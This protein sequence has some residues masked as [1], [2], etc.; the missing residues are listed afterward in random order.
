MRRRGL[1]FKLTVLYTTIFSVLLSGFFVFAYYL[2]A[3]Q[4][5]ATAT[6]E[7][8]ERATG[9]KGYLRFQN[10][11]PTLVFDADDPDVAYFS[12]TATRYY[13]IYDYRSG[14]LVHQSKELALMGMQFN[15]KEILQ[16]SEGPALMDI[17]TDQGPL[18]FYNDRIVNVLNYDTVH[19]GITRL[20]MTSV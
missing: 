13:Q 4:L 14:D 18:R 9:L 12:R 15:P 10:G 5:E 20:A 17:Q 3:N 6:D 16:F 11:A 1:R 7:L 8:L 19:D 2:L